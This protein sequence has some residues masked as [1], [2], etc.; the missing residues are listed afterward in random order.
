[1]TELSI[2]V[3][4]FG[5]RLPKTQVFNLGQT[6][7]LN[8]FYVWQHTLSSQETDQTESLRLDYVESP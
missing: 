8:R 3:I 1:M 4:W 6:A 7:A 2:I 5:L